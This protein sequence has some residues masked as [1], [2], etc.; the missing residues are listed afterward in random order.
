ML[1]LLD[2]D[3]NNFVFLLLVLAVK[4]YVHLEN[5]QKV[6]TKPVTSS[7]CYQENYKHKFL[8]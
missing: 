1:Q 8:Q 6:E 4:S 3:L 5:T 2:E 7:Y